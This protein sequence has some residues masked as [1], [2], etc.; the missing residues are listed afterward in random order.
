MATALTI[1]ILL[2][3]GA[4][5]GIGL[6]MLD[7]LAA[8]VKSFNENTA[9]W[10][11][12]LHTNLEGLQKSND[13]I[14]VLIQE[15]SR[16]ALGACAAHTES[17]RGLSRAVG[18]FEGAIGTLADPGHLQDWV[19]ALHGAVAPLD[20][21]RIS[22]ETHYA[23]S[24][25]VLNSTGQVLEQWSAQRARV[26]ESYLKVAEVLMTWSQN[27][28]ASRQ[29]IE[30]R[31]LQRLQEQGAQSQLVAENL[32]ALQT[33]IQA[34]A[35]AVERV[36]A[37]VEH[38]LQAQDNATN[39]I[40]RLADAHQAALEEDRRARAELARSQKEAAGVMG[41]VASD[42]E[43]LA[44]QVQ[45]T[46]RDQTTETHNFVSGLRTQYREDLGG[47]SQSLAAAQTL[48]EG[49]TQGQKDFLNRANRVLTGLP[50]RSDIYTLA[51][52]GG[53]FATIWGIHAFLR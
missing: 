27:E 53:L 52:M 30:R 23:V 12:A 3:G 48:L 31:I 18:S 46:I 28:E 10:M 24:R 19:E 15:S 6:A 47:M 14:L 20:A 26:E 49:L 17:T 35:N 9:A 7:G 34:M 40:S 4:I 36:N 39:S 8:G 29:E 13:A 37:T 51:V 44:V 21:L 32:G 1:L 5:G 16:Q 22:L 11:Q 43:S 2:L 41:R 42:V 25:G 33:Q 50:L 45:R 38:T